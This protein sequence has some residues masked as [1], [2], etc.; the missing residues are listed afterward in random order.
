MLRRAKKPVILAVNKVDSYQK[1]MADVYEFY[2][3]GIGEP[4]PISATN[5][6]G[7]GE[8]LDEVISFRGGGD[9]GRGGRSYQGRHRRQTE[10]RKIFHHQ[11]FD[12]GE[13]SDRF[14]YCGNNQRCRGYGNYP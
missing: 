13:P 4:F 5:K 8:L 2:N 14:G 11:P 9:R 3:L 6:L 1:Y 12:R 7:F 10:C